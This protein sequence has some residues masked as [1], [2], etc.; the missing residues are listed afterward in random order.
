VNTL[1]HH[2]FNELFVFLHRTGLYNRQKNMWESIARILG[3]NVYQSRRGLFRKQPLPMYDLHFLDYRQRP[4]IAAHLIKSDDQ[5]TDKE[6]SSHLNSFLGR[7]ARWGGL[8]GLLFCAPSPIP[9]TVSEKV[10]KIT[11]GDDPVARYES[12]LPAPLAV[13]L[14]ILEMVVPVQAE[15]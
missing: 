8:T 14:D 1:V 3:V 9:S 10:S 2:V 15:D 6:I 7:A 5:M 13:P 4:L 12:V 11:N